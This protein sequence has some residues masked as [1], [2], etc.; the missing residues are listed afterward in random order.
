M[1]PFAKL[2]P[3]DHSAGFSDKRTARFAH[4]FHAHPFEQIGEFLVDRIE[5]GADSGWVHAGVDRRK[6]AADIQHVHRNASTFDHLLRHFHGDA[7][8]V[9]V[10]ALR[11]D[12]EANAKLF[13][14][15]AG[16]FKQFLRF[17]QVDAELVREI[18]LGI[19]IR[20]RQANEQVQVTRIARFLKDFVEFF[21]GIEREIAHAIFVIRRA[22]RC[23]GFHRM[24]EKQGG[25]REYFPNRFDLLQRSHV[26]RGDAELIKLAQHRCVR[27]GFNGVA[28]TAFE[29]IQKEIRSTIHRMGAV[30]VKGFFPDERPLPGHEQNHVCIPSHKASQDLLTKNRPTAVISRM[31]G[32]LFR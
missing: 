6:P 15:S 19:G 17:R 16:E 14:M 8:R 23:A 4:Q 32:V 31:K 20:N 10:H 29:V 24:H 11:P 30:N 25:I 26:E 5:I 13:G 1:L 12:M 9:R 22:D 18:Q 7:I 28:D 2:H 21:R 27:I 3:H